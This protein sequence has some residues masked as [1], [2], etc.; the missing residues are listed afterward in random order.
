MWFFGNKPWWK[1]KK[2]GW[3]KVAGVKDFFEESRKYADKGQLS[4]AI[5]VLEWGRVYSKEVGSGG[6]VNAFTTMINKI[7]E[8]ISIRARF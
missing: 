1:D 5:E 7:E 8:E 6:G 4:T 2:K 3:K